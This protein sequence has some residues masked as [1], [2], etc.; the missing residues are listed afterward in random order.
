MPK[1]YLLEKSAGE[2]PVYKEKHFPP[3][4]NLEKTVVAATQLK[5]LKI[6][7]NIFLEKSQIFLFSE[8]NSMQDK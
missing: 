6:W 8:Q 2:V 5:T 7:K 3:V 1:E 4:G